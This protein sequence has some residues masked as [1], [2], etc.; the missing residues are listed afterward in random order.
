MD[1]SCECY[2]G[3]APSVFK[4]RIVTARKPHKCCECKD[5]IPKG[6][7]YERITGLWDGKWDEFKMCIGCSRI[8]EH[9]CPCAEFGALNEYVIEVYNMPLVGNEWEEWVNETEKED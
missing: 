2:D 1:C 3:E 4:Q 9:I 5:V 6:T 7:K 8:R